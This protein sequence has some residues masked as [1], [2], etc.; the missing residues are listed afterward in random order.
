MNGSRPNSLLLVCALM[1]MELSWRYAWLHTLGVLTLPLAFPWLHA[2]AAYAGAVLLTY[3]TAGRGLRLITCFTI[4]LICFG[5]LSY[6]LVYSFHG[7]GEGWFDMAWLARLPEA[8]EPWKAWL[9]LSIELLLTAWIWISGYNLA[10]KP[11]NYD[12]VNVRFDIGL[13]SFFLLIFFSLILAEPFKVEINNDIARPMMISFFCFGLLSLSLARTRGT[14]VRE[15]GS[16]YRGLGSLFTFLSITLSI[17]VGAVAFFMPYMTTAAETGYNAVKTVMKPMVPYL[18]AFLKYLFA[19]SWSR[20]SAETSER[21]STDGLLGESMGE[22]GSW[23]D[24]A[25]Q[26]AGWILLGLMALVFLIV[27]AYLLYRL[28]LKLISRTNMVPRRI[29]LLDQISDWFYRWSIKACRWLWHTFF[30]KGGPI[31]VYASLLGW[32]RRSGMPRRRGETPREY[33]QRLAAALPRAAGQIETII[34]CLEMAVFAGRPL[35]RE[36]LST[37]RRSKRH[38]AKPGLWVQ[39]FL[40]WLPR[41]EVKTHTHLKSS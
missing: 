25:A 23:L 36:E 33:G 35:G 2:V 15:I 26:V 10:R 38:L 29:N 22:S 32:G 41:R 27:L 19:N 37:L 24:V 39:R 40:S 28:Y 12:P 9:A 16:G 30:Q 20:P 34:H 11:K 17:A 21:N 3:L 18:V 1:G 5:L 14:V 31:E 4:H 8:P 7:A 6:H 13:T